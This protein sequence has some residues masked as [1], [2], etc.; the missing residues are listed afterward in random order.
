MITRRNNWD[1]FFSK[2]FEDKKAFEVKIQEIID[3]RNQIAHFHSIRFNEAVTVIQ[4]IL[5]I[6][7]RMRK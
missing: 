4:N 1:S 7:I 6:L 2:Y 5:W 3:T